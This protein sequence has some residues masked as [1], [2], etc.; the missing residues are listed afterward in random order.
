MHGWHCYI[1]KTYPLDKLS[2]L[3][4]T[5]PSC[6]T[7]LSV[8]GWVAASIRCDNIISIQNKDAL[9][10]VLCIK[11]WVNPWFYHFNVVHSQ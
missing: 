3:R 1:V 11:H 9:C 8:H 2:K 4:T 6:L 10:I 7:C 5:G